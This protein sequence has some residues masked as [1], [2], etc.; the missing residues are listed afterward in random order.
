MRYVLIFCLLLSGC[1]FWKHIQD[2]SD[3]LETGEFPCP[4]GEQCLDLT[5]RM[6][7]LEG[8]IFDTLEPIRGWKQIGCVHS[9]QI[10]Y[11][12][13]EEFMYCEYCQGKKQMWMIYDYDWE[14][15]YGVP[16]WYPYTPPNSECGDPPILNRNIDKEN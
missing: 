15:K 7:G 2:S 9:K 8:G 16:D 14:G 5:Q 6:G 4:E 11:T 13:K 1:T 3:Y 10:D 12:M